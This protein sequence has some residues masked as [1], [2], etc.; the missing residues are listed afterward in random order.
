[1]KRWTGDL[2]N[3]FD[4]APLMWR[5]R[6]DLRAALL[7]VSLS[8]LFDSG[9]T[10]QASL[11]K[12]KVNA[13]PWLKWHISRM[14]RHLKQ[15]P[16]EPMRALETGIFSTLIV[17]KIADAERRDNFVQAI[18]LLGRDSLES[19]VEAVRR[20][21]RIT[22]LALLA[23]AAIVFMV[24]GLGSYLMTGLVGLQNMMGSGSF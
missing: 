3:K 7:I 9:L 10:I 15:R 2:R 11:E 20:N 14:L 5:N 1:L 17:D 12:I 21:A 8:G 24:V 16:E 19:V 6:R 4:N 18:K 22:H 13:D 23:F